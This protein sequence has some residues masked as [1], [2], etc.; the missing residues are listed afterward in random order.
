M[1][2]PSIFFKEGSCDDVLHDI[3]IV[4]GD[5]GSAY[6]IVSAI[7]IQLNSEYQ[8]LRLRSHNDKGMVYN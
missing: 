7:F 6:Q 1:D 2:A 3:E 4:G 8:V 5:L